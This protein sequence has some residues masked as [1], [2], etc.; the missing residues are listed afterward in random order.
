MP[1][2]TQVEH[3]RTSSHGE[4]FTGEGKPLAARLAVFAY[5]TVSYAIFFGTY[6][7]AIAFIGNFSSI[8]PR[9]IDGEPTLSL[10][11]AL[12]INLAL[13]GIFAVQHSVMARP[14][15]KQ[16]WTRIIPKPLERPT[17]VLFSSIALIALFYFW[18][19]M[20]GQVWRF[21]S[22]AAQ[23]ILYAIFALGW[24]LVLYSTFLINHFDLF[25]LRHVWLYLRGK[26]YTPLKF[27]TPSAYKIVRHPLYVGWLMAFWATPTMTLA[28]LVFAVMTTAYILVAIQL[29]ERNLVEA[30]PEYAAYRQRVPM[31]LPRPGRRWH[32]AT[33]DTKAE[34]AV[35]KMHRA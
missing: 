24:A 33:P 21:E 16:W 7:Y 30:H 23:A 13:L 32:D 19:P 17:Y 14:T 26:P 2:Q 34:P 22:I 8:V 3:S 15:F 18:Q 12:L 6:L 5:G 35:A 27:A 25:G 1:A 29:E 28:H 31:L 10:T 20:G 11:L 4:Y 9:T